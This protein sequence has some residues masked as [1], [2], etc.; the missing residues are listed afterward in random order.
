MRRKAERSAAGLA[1]PIDPIGYLQTVRRVEVHWTRPPLHTDAR[2]LAAA[3]P[4]LRFG[5]CNS[6]WYSRF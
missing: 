3:R 2:R 1:A 5:P 6:V 4:R